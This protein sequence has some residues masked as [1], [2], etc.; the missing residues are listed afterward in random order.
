MSSDAVVSIRNLDHFYGHDSLQKQVLFDVGFD[1]NPGEIVL[2]TGPSG[3]GKTTLLTLIG[4]LRSVQAGTLSVLGQEL[5]GASQRQRVE[6]RRNIG[7]I[8]QA[9]NLLR[10]L[11]ASQNVQMTL[12]LQADL[13]W[14]E[15]I[16]RS[17]Q[18]LE[19]VGLGDHL[20]YYP[21]NLSGGQKQRV[22]IARALV[23]RPKLVL[24]DEPT[25]ALDRQ[26]GR[27]VVDLMQQLAKE[28]GCTILLVTHDNR[29]L[30]IADRILEME[31]GRLVKGGLTS[32]VLQKA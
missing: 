5:H 2:L 10:F 31:D 11:T 1:L 17:H 18:M 26:S 12:D 15:R 32:P 29:I 16:A 25:A 14:D 27:D 28:Q 6:V 19:A 20:D 7:Y 23:G 24:A 21:E 4:G 3:C 8:F 22:A 13:N 9:H 30:D